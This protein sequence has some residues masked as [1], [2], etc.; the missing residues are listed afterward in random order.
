MAVTKTTVISVRVPPDIKAALTAA[1]QA[2]RRS[3]ATMVE[4]MVL[5]Y[6]RTRSIPLNP[7]DMAAAA[8]TAVPSRK[9]QNT[10]RKT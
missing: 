2:E 3:L 7:V 8:E 1:A 4:V 9:K 6:C 10:S 5:D